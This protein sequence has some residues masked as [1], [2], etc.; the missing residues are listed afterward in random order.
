MYVV[1][2]LFNV[3][4]D[5]IASFRKAVLQQAQKSLS[6]EPDC[7]GFDVCFDPNDDTRILL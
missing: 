1:T 7:R 4:N 5:Y 2:V 3:K 6:R